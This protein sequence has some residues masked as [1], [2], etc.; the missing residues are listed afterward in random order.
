M[1]ER[2]YQGVPIA[3]IL[4]VAGLNSDLTTNMGDPRNAAYI[5]PLEDDVDED[6]AEGM[7]AASYGAACAAKGVV[8]GDEMIYEQC[9]VDA[10]RM[11]CDRDYERLFRD[12]RLERGL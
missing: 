7:A 12:K 6:M 10:R 11:I 3:D 1:S 2:D 8:E 9:L 5:G 4:K